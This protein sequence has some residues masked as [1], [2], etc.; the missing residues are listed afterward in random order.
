MS[1]SKGFDSNSSF[2]HFST[3]WTH[4]EKSSE[5]KNAYFPVS[6]FLRMKL[7]LIKVVVFGT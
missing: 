1:R 6:F 5:F 3:K 4:S 7:S 2:I